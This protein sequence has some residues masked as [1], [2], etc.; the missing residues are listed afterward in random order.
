MAGRF[1]GIAPSPKTPPPN[2]AFKHHI[3]GVPSKR[4]TPIETCSHLLL[5]TN[6]FEISD[7]RAGRGISKIALLLSLD[8]LISGICC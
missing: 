3:K 5:M 2:G 8:L 7:V 4:E 6:P 1:E